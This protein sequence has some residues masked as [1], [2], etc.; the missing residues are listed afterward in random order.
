MWMVLMALQKM[1]KRILK[2]QSLIKKNLLLLLK[3]IW[4]CGI[5]K[6]KE[7][8]GKNFNKELAWAAVAEMLK[9]ISGE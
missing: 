9:N 8:S 5:K 3:L 7:Y 6:Q 1:K 4:Y 2:I